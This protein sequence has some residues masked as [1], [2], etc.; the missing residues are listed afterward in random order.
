MRQTQQ[1]AEDFKG[2]LAADLLQKSAG[3]SGLF[4]PGY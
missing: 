2:L 1:A 3:R 4:N